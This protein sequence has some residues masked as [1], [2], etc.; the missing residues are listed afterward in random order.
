MGLDNSRHVH[1]LAG[2]EAGAP[3]LLTPPLAGS[4]HARRSSVKPAQADDDLPP[5]Q[6]QAEP[7]DPE[8]SDT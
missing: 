3:I 2:V 1:I 5:H 8:L 6:R 7:A 4:D